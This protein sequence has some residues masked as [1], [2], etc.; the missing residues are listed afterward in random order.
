MS[1]RAVHQHNTEPSLQKTQKAET[2]PFLV[3]E[4]SIVKSAAGYT[5]PK[6]QAFDGLLAYCGKH[7]GLTVSARGLGHWCCGSIWS[8][9]VTESHAEPHTAM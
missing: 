5:C 9:W 4:H 3:E 1:L 2:G 6:R 7:R 8:C